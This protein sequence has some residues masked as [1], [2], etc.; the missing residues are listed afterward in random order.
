M[1]R[2]VAGCVLVVGGCTGGQ[3]PVVALDPFFGSAVPGEALVL[4]GT[5]SDAEDEATTLDVLW[6]SDLGGDLGA[7]PPAVDGTVTL[8]V[9]LGE[10]LHTVSLQVTDRG[11]NTVQDS[12]LVAVGDVGGPDCA[13]L[14]PL[15]GDALDRSGEVLVRANASDDET[16]APE[17]LITLSSDVDGE[18][19]HPVATVDG[20]V[21]SYLSGLTPG[22]HT[23]TLL[24]VDGDG[25]SCLASVGVVLGEGPVVG[26][27]EPPSEVIFNLGEPINF[28]AEASDPDGDAGALT[29]TWTSNINGVIG[30]GSSID[31]YAALL[32]GTHR[33]TAEAVDA[34]GLIGTDEVLIGVNSP[35]GLSVMQFQN[36]SPTS[37]DDLVAEPIGTDLDGP[38]PVVFTWTW[39]VDGVVDPR[40]TG[41]TVPASATERGQIWDASAVPFD[42]LAYGPPA[43]GSVVIRN[44]PPAVSNVIVTGT[45]SNGGLLSC[46]ADVTDL[47]ANDIVTTDIRW[48]AQATGAE[49]SSNASYTVSTAVHTPGTLLTC[50]VQAT[51]DAGDST[52]YDT[53]VAVLNTPPVVVGAVSLSPAA[54]ARVGEV[55]R[56]RATFSDP[57]GHAL[58]TSHTWTSLVSGAVL[59]NTEALTVSSGDPGTGGEVECRVGATDLYG[60]SVFTTT[61]LR[62]INSAPTLQDV[63]VTPSPAYND[64]LLTCSGRPLDPDQDVLSYGYVWT[65]ASDGA[66]VGSARTLQLNPALARPGDAFTCTFTVT[67]PAGLSASGFA[68]RA[69]LNREPVITQVRITPDPLTAVDVASCAPVG[70]VDL[71]G[72]PIT[73]SYYMEVGG[74]GPMVFSN[75]LEGGY[76]RGDQVTC[77]VWADDPHGVI[78]ASSAQTSVIVANSPPEAPEVIV[79]PDLPLAGVDDLLCEIREP[80]FDIDGDV[81][82]YTMS[83]VRDGVTEA[84]L[85]GTWPGD[86][87]PG[88]LTGADETWTCV[89]TPFDGQDAGL[90]GEASAWVWGS[91]PTL[92]VGSGETVS[93]DEGDYLYGD[94]LVQA[95]GVLRIDGDVFV[96]ARSFT[97]EAGG[98]V[99]GDGGGFAGGLAVGLTHGEGPGGGFAG[100]TGGGSGAGHG[101]RGADASDG[102]VGGAIYADAAA[103]DVQPGSGGGAGSADGGAG[104]AALQVEAELIAIAGELFVVGQRGVPGTGGGGGGGSGG[105]V[106]LRAEVLEVTGV[107][108]AG[109]GGPGGPGAGG[110]GGGTVQLRYDTSFVGTGSYTAQGQG[111]GRA[112]LLLV[113]QADWP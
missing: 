10:G 23:L 100:T 1:R 90:A 42:G 61:R 106:L 54:T 6:S 17:L 51:D 34:D 69:I 18:L 76:S 15:D 110:G 47:D 12:M 41:N 96:R 62:V 45:P 102:T 40:W 25:L 89:A 86:T 79:G 80:A 85:T 36:P 107:I 94:V 98:L 13:F 67:D 26:I 103:L 7:D 75:T 74:G 24:V 20:V 29:V 97:V 2:L 71:D 109:G 111:G 52:T 99:D 77:R 38:E 92:T 39:W 50:R 87:L 78:G 44:S 108:R 16:E 3:P 4:T 66:S 31:A 43:L 58:A 19:D 21:R 112:G 32:P 49:L 48:V 5:V 28:V 60:G 113:T 35:P 59:G 37:S 81:A 73:Y 53:S 27:V 30:T 9:S 101:G 46:T 91:L 70:A 11:R 63:Q 8:E 14:T 95:G 57:D 64:S 56:C 65:R 68:Q 104:G 84:G 83:W 88:A 22:A 93:L 33:I 55:V 105:G 82:S 72:D